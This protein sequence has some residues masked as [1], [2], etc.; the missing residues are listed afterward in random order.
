MVEETKQE[1]EFKNEEG[2]QAEGTIAGENVGA[3]HSANDQNGAQMTEVAPVNVGDIVKGKVTKVEEKQALV[4]VGYKVDGILPISEVS[5]LHIDKVGDV[6][7]EGDELT[8]QVIRYNQEKDEVILSKRAIDREKAWSDLEKK[9]ETGEIFEAVVAD[10]VK[11]GLVVDVGV[12]GFIPASMV[13]RHFVEDF[14]DY[15]GNTLR[16]KVVELDKEKNKVILSHK[17][18][19]DDEYENQKKNVI[20]Q[21]KEGQVIEGTVQRLTDFGVFVDLGGIDGLV[22]ISELAWN[23]VE[24][25]S[26]VVQEGDK[27]KVKVLGV[28][29]EKE[30]IS[31]S[32][33]QTQQGPWE[34]AGQGIKPGDVI[35]GKVKRLVG[36]GAFVEIAPGVEGL[37]HISQI[38]NRHIAT[39]SEVLQ[40]GQEVQ[41]KVL[42]VNV[43]EKRIS[44]SIRALQEDKERQELKETQSNYEQDNAGLGVTIGDLFGDLKDKLK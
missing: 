36:F 35:T 21:L 8:L 15:K 10:V 12:R 16:L 43:K 41:V 32:I 9:L 6:L 37:V 18:V 27:V 40:E 33:K 13:E 2:K 34:Q 31:L 4:D 22:H 17:A 26:D 29:P 20:N 42:D 30:R 38:A 44:L 39:P 25:A 5:S 23:H 14:S 7:Q 11:G 3:D 24:K 19:L 28:N 1:V